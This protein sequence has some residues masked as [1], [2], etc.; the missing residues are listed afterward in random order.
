MKH[1]QLFIDSLINP[2][3]LAAYRILP[4]GKVIQYVFLLITFLTLF[5]FG[6]FTTG[7]TDDLFNMEGL[8]DYIDDIKWILYPMAFIF[9]FVMNS[10]IIFLRISLYAFAGFYLMKSM[11]RRG[12]YRQMWRTAAF[13]STWATI[14]SIVFT[15]FQLSSSVSTLIGVFITM[16]LLIVAITKYPKQ[17]KS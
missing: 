4:I 13:A 17:P 1:S 5:S 3:K 11:N 6:R 16:A 2:K 7:V 10:L 15:I 8:T 9:L 14:L 12:E